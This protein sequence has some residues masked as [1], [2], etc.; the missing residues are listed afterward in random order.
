M[1]LQL[2]LELLLLKLLLLKLLLLELLLLELLRKLLLRKHLLNRG[3]RGQSLLRVIA[4]CR[5][6]CRRSL[7]GE[8]SLTGS[9]TSLLVK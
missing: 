6:S 2:L 8:K 9:E 7:P 4:S 1:L 3:R 5:R